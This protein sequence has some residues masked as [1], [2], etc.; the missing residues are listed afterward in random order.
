LKE[1]D[2][3]ILILGIILYPIVLYR[4][5]IGLLIEND[6]ISLFFKQMVKYYYF[7]D[8]IRIEEKLES[9]RY[10]TTYVILIFLTNNKK[11]RLAG[12]MPNDKKLYKS[13]ISSFNNKT[14]KS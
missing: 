13:L 11:L 8:I 4:E 6:K 5:P 3:A 12:F 10:G 2:G 9:N 1:Y 14:N 7:K